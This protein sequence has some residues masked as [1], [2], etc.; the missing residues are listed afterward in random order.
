MQVV[1]MMV[2]PQLGIR[3]NPTHDADAVNIDGGAIDGAV[4]GVN[5]WCGYYRYN[6]WHPRFV[7]DLTGT[8]L[9]SV[10]V[11]AHQ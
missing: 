1:P 5:F 4:I 9:P 3:C 10:L 7:G 11:N 8:A 2:E 6:N